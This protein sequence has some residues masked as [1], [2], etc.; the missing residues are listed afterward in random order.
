[1]TEYIKFSG[2]EFTTELAIKAYLKGKK[3]AEIPVAWH[4]RE[5][6]KQKSNLIKPGVGYFKVL[7][8]LLN[9]KAKIRKK[10]H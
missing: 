5:E 3:F 7:L 2:F 1:M 6:G 10:E 4:N 9:E 8:L